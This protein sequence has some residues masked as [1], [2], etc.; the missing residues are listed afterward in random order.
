MPEPQYDDDLYDFEGFVFDLDYVEYA[1]QQKLLEDE[2]RAFAHFVIS[3][4]L[5]LFGNDPTDCE[6]NR[7]GK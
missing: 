7:L 4:K 3:A 1:Y 2:R 5:V 6:F